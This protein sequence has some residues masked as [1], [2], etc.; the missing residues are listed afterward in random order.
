ME[1]QIQKIVSLPLDVNEVLKF[2]PDKFNQDEKAAIQNAVL[3]M[4]AGVLFTFLLECKAEKCIYGASCPFYSTKKFPK[5][6]KCPM[7]RALAE[8]WTREYMEQFDVSFKE[9]TDVT[10][11]QTLVETD[12]EIMRAKAELA[13]EGFREVVVTETETS[14]TFSKKLNDLVM[15][16]EKWHEKRMR[17]LKALNATRESGAKKVSDPSVLAAKMKQKLEKKMRGEFGA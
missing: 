13:S 6:E 12:I 7:E 17:I 3:N 5:G 4:S 15:A 2:V 16:V 10:M 14:K 8:K 1:N 9:R 11:I